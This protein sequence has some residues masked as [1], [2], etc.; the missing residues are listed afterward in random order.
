MDTS[1]M[2]VSPEI[3]LFGPVAMVAAGQSGD[4]TV[5]A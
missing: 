2:G 3:L 1:G 4:F 5:P